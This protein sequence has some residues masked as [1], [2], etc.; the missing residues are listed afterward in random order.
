MALSLAREPFGT[1]P[2]GS[3]V[4]RITLSSDIGISLSVITWGCIITGIQV[5]DRSGRREEITL[6]HDTL[7][8]Y[9]VRHPYFGAAVGRFA[10]RI[11]GGRFTLDGREYQLAVNNGSNHLHGGINGFDRQLWH[12]EPFTTETGAVGVR[13]ARTSPDGEE[14]YPGSLDVTHDIV[15]TDDWTFELRFRAQCDA[16]T[17]VNL[18]NHAYYNLSGEPTI[19]DHVVEVPSERYVPVEGGIPTGIEAVAGT[20]WDFRSPR[21]VREAHEALVEQGLPKGLDH[22]Y[23]INGWTDD[24]TMR[25]A[26]TVTAPASG[27][28]MTVSTTY[29][30]VQVYE[31]GNLPGAIGRDGAP[32]S[33][34]EALCLE[35]QYFP[36]SP[37]QGGFPSAVLRPGERYSHV[38][39]HQFEIV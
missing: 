4:D 39:R 12:V 38:T 35:C 21:P 16:P 20:P 2:D 30:A 27:R 10:N 14:G 5:P 26:A 8:R 36:D 29:P 37:N 13:F 32:L 9:T 17:I 18:T 19:H 23:A 31:G 34:F 6:G 7:E 1:L 15:L 25:R 24:K 11:A 22:S 33:G 28:R 3:A